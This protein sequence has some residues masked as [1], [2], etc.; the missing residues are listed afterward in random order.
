MMNEEEGKRLRVYDNDDM[1][2][3]TILFHFTILLLGSVF[4]QR[5]GVM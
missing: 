5:S 3:M 2:M 4:S 1:K